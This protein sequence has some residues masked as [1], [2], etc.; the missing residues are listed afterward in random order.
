M[1]IKV[2]TQARARVSKADSGV[3]E[4]KRD[5]DAVELSVARLTDAADGVGVEVARSSK[6][7]RDTVGWWLFLGTALIAFGLGVKSLQDWVR[8]Q[9]KS[10]TVDL[11]PSASATLTGLITDPSSPSF[12]ISFTYSDT[13][14]QSVQNGP[15][16]AA[17]DAA[18][19]KWRQVIP[20][21]FPKSKIP[22]LLYDPDNGDCRSSSAFACAN[23][24][25]QTVYWTATL[26]G[27]AKAFSVET[28]MLHELGHLLGVPHIEGDRLMNPVY[29]GPVER[30]S[31]MAVVIAKAKIAGQ[32]KE[33]RNEYF[34]DDF[35][36]HLES[37]R[38]RK[39]QPQ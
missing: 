9:S 37:T 5:W 13:A 3:N 36:V 14:R 22:K 7:G 34:K 32:L 35:K 26:R 21:A 30:P 31:K 1:T 19:A 38:T 23:E 10:P 2:R 16:R 33:N 8:S 29:N 17:F 18:V 12:S 11:A 27:H 24:Y 25:T 20:K 28:V 39:V 15:I 4:R 6:T